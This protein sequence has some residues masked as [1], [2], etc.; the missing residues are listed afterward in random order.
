MLAQL[1]QCAGWMHAPIVVHSSAIQNKTGHVAAGGG[2]HHAMDLLRI[3]RPGLT[4]TKMGNRVGCRPCQRSL[5]SKRNAP[6]VEE[7]TT[8]IGVPPEPPP[9]TRN[10]LV[11]T[12]CVATLLRTGACT[13]VR[14]YVCMYACMYV[15]LCLHGLKLTRHSPRLF[16][17][18]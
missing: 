18:L 1:G 2:R 13:Y 10:F 8:K 15:C 14:M 16:F 17:S 6:L 9:C 3:A 4:P 5:K 7:A 12:V 11:N